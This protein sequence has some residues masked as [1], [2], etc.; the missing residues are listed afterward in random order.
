MK[1]RRIALL[2]A[3]VIFLSTIPNI[4]FA[5]D[6]DAYEI[7]RISG[8]NRYETAIQIAKSLPQEQSKNVVLVDGNGFADALSGGLYAIQ[9]N[10]VILLANKNG[11][12]E[13]TKSYIKEN[14]INQAVILGGFNSV[15]EKVE[16]E[17]NILGIS[18]K[19]I[20]GSNRYVTS[21]RVLLDIA[22][23]LGVDALDYTKLAL[24]D[25][26]TFADALTAAPYMASSSVTFKGSLLLYNPEQSENFEGFIFGGT[27][28]IPSY[29][30]SIK[31]FAGSNRYETAVEIANQYGKSNGA[32]TGY[33]PSEVVIASGED[34][35]DALASAPFVHSRK[36][37]LLLSSKDGLD[38][39][40]IEYIYQMGIKKI[41]IIGGES[42]VPNKVIEQIVSQFKSPLEQYVN[43]DFNFSFEYPNDLIT[44]SDEYQSGNGITISNDFL[45]INVL[46]RPYEGNNDFKQ[47]LEDDEELDHL[48][49]EPD[50]MGGQ[51]AWKASI[52]SETGFEWMI[53]TIKDGTQYI[54]RAESDYRFPSFN[55]YQQDQITEIMN[56]FRF[57]K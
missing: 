22:S 56:S 9:T 54:I 32:W 50:T 3:F 6:N 15:S 23:L 21:D 30:K 37:V 18:N 1:N 31:R 47:E 7:E 34:Y 19:R 46:A 16:E 35:P 41:T 20:S 48:K 29:I 39:K 28:R 27:S 55:Q 52:F 36:A 25:G 24:V 40:S 14:N 13:D 5:V 33:S 2:V 53:T 11:L 57:L 38:D 45:T 49:L 10:S 43:N 51:E 4:A 12:P 42:S 17:L 26:L 8:S 44:R